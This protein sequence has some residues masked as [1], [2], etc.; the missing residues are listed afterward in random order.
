MNS[1]MVAALN[2]QQ[3]SS[4]PQAGLEMD[5]QSAKFENER[6]GPALPENGIPMTS[7]Q[8]LGNRTFNINKTSSSIQKTANKNEESF[9]SHDNKE[10][11]IK[12]SNGGG[13]ESSSALS[14]V[15]LKSSYQRFNDN[16]FCIKIEFGIALPGFLKLEPGR[17][18]R[19][20]ENNQIGQGGTSLIGRGIFCNPELAQKYGTHEIALKFYKG[21]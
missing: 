5:I 2:V 6:S 14:T 21:K 13:S 4:Q 10:D 17:D 11:T 19:I 1:N 16:I 15:K 7:F 20:V 12:I 9:N 18:F 8:Q 3:V